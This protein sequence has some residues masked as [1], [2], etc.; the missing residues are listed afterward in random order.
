MSGRD[1]LL[2]A[3]TAF[4]AK[5]YA[6]A[7][8]HAQEALRLGLDIN[9]PDSERGE[10]A[11]KEESSSCETLLAMSLLESGGNLDA[12][13]E[14]CNRAVN[15]AREYARAW[16]NRGHLRRERGELD[17]ALEDLE[18]AL[19]YDRDYVFARLRRAQCLQT[20]GRLEEAEQDLAQILLKNPCDAFP[21]ELWQEIRIQRGLPNDA[22]ALPTPKDAAAF[23]TRGQGFAQSN[24]HLRAIADFD[25]AVALNRA[26]IAF[27]WRGLSHRALGNLVQAKADL[28]VWVKVDPGWAPAVAAIDA[29]LK[30]QSSA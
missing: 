9:A 25:A 24:E 7:S 16:G 4:A 20:L 1:Q 5:D 12:A 30:A 22:A 19:K 11:P 27:L 14:H 21:F 3:E 23:I 15:F 13:L 29:A 2:L 6:K 17:L 8:E 10:Y 26:P 18:W 28:E